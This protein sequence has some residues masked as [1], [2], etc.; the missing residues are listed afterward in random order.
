LIEIDRERALRDLQALGKRRAW[1]E[2]EQAVGGGR[3][4]FLG[5]AL[6]RARRPEDAASVYRPI[7]SCA[8]RATIASVYAGL[9]K[10]APLPELVAAASGA[11]SSPWPKVLC[12]LASLIDGDPAA[13]STTLRVATEQGAAA[14][15][16]GRLEA[17]AAALSAG[18]PLNRDDIGVVGLP[19][20]VAAALYLVHGGDPL[21]VRAAAW[22]TALGNRWI[23]LC[24]VSP[25]RVA[26]SLLSAWCADSSWERALEFATGLERSGQAWGR[27]VA[28]L[29]KI[30]HALSRALSGRLSDARDELGDIGNGIIS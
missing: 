12:A 22:V 24:P 2:R 3:L 27:E 30:R 23:E 9:R 14:P 15:V 6:L 10:R 25:E 7:S 20:E 28:A 19:S 26:R 4:V 17:V 29:T 11:A 21:P 1:Q 18:V 8:E 16:V 13:A 5:D